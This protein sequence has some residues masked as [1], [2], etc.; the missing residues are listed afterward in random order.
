MAAQSGQA[1]VNVPCLWLHVRSKPFPQSFTSTNADFEAQNTDWTGHRSCPPLF[2]QSKLRAWV[3]AG[4]HHECDFCRLADLCFFDRIAGGRFFERSELEDVAWIASGGSM[5]LGR[6]R[7][8]RNESSR[9][10]GLSAA[11]KRC[12]SNAEVRPNHP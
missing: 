12:P 2:V 1:V 11:I 7:G 6:P 9:R 3:I 4:R 10:L 8:H 5:L